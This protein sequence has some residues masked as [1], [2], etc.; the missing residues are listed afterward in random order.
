MAPPDFPAIIAVDPAFSPMERCLIEESIA[1][2]E[3]SAPMVVIETYTGIG[4]SN[5]TIYKNRENMTDAGP[6]SWGW[7]E[8]AGGDIHLFT[9]RLD[10]DKASDLEGFRWW[11]VTAAMH[12]LG[13][14]MGLA[15]HDEDRPAAAHVDG[16]MTFHS[17]YNYP[18][19]RQADLDAFCREYPCSYQARACEIEV[20]S[21]Q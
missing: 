17:N 6:E 15:H 4:N 12:E 16:I 20:P 5:P 10:R 19:I 11:F 21:C 9:D 13:H 14:F 8:G 18:C 2:W 1:R 7:S 3:A